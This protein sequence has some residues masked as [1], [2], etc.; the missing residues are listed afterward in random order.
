MDDVKYISKE[1]YDAINERSQVATGDILFA[2]I[3]SIGNPSI[4]GEKHEYAIKNVALFKQVFPV[5]ELY[6]YYYLLSEQDSMKKKASGG[7]QPF[8]SLGY[9]RNYLLPLPPVSEQQRIVDRVNEL[10]ALCDEL[11]GG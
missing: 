1:D 10:L 2:M 3:G 5:N 9:L 7:V 4:V 11:I 6:L 8:V